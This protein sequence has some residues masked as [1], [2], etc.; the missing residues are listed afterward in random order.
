MGVLFVF[1][2]TGRAISPRPWGKGYA[3]GRLDPIPPEDREAIIDLF[4]RYVTSNFVAFFDSTV[5]CGFFDLLVEAGVGSP[6]LAGRRCACGSPEK[7]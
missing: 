5:G 2:G 7:R 4:N 6:A 1:S 3:D